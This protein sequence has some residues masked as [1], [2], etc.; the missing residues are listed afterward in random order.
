M[1]IALSPAALEPAKLNF[2]AGEANLI[3]DPEM[4]KG[5]EMAIAICFVEYLCLL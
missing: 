1:E 5:E 3:S 4:A 2:R